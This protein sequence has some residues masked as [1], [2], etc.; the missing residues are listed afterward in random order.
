MKITPELIRY[1]QDNV[2]R[3]EDRLVAGERVGPFIVEPCEQFNP[4]LRSAPKVEDYVRPRIIFW[5]PIHQHPFFKGS[6]ACPHHD[7]GGEI[8]VLTPC[9][10]KDGKSERD[11]PRAIYCV[12][13]PLLLVSRVYRCIRGH[14]IAGHDPRLLERIPNGDVTFHL[15]HK[16]GISSQLC[17]LVFSLASS[18]QTFNEIEI[19]LAQRYLDSF[20]ERECRYARHIAS[21]L[22][23]NTVDKDS[24]APFPSFDIWGPTP[25]TDTI[26][27]CFLCVYKENRLFLGQH[28]SDTTA[29]SW[30]SADHTF[31]VAA[32]IGCY[33]PD[34]SWANQFDSL[35]IVLNEL[36]QVLTYKL[37]K[38]TAMNKVEDILK[39]LKCRLEQQGT[40]CHTI[41]V[42]NCCTVR[43]KFTEIFPD[44]LIKLDLFH[45]IQRVTSKVPKDRKHYLSPSFINDFRMIFRAD[46]DQGVTREMDT[47]DEG[48][49]MSNLEK[50]AE[51]WR[52]VCYDS[53]EPVLNGNICRELENLKIHIKKGCL[54]R[55][56]TGGGSARNENLHKNL[57]SVIAR[58]KLGCELAEALLATFFYVWNERRNTSGQMP[59]GCVKP[60]LS[61]R[62]ELE[63]HGF[64]PT[65]ERFGIIPSSV[66]PEEQHLPSSCSPEAML[67]IL[68]SIGCPAECEEH[69]TENLSECDLHSVLCQAVN[70]SVVYSHLKSLCNSPKLNPRLIHLMPCSLM[71]FSNGTYATNKVA[72]HSERLD[73]N[74]M[75]YQLKVNEELHFNCTADSMFLS[76]ISQLKEMSPSSQML[77][78]H[79]SN[80]G[81][82]LFVDDNLKNIQAL[83]TVVVDE[84]LS[85]AVHYKHAMLTAD[86]TYEEETNKF[87]KCGY[88]SSK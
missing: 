76:V 13:G 25:S 79:L 58:S 40:M 35:F 47:P 28:M 77:Q 53:G 75:G 36:G 71:L 46:G 48:T 3:Y 27:Q 21:F 51:R 29:A 32:N 54:S 7:H 65:T 52:H 38:G 44:A 41:F 50:F 82:S 72:E 60:I 39:N 84:L 6:F 9:K 20:S 2:Q 22:S 14:E 10:W 88:Y 67:G 42:D 43:G 34:G 80:L 1:V 15:G 18:G 86:L 37:T 81:L 19:F 5:D 62:A 87:K 66:D 49:L 8:S 24:L 64:V 31:K 73:K 70:A 16:L 12:N 26:L 4:D 57:R 30:I 78:E 11:L 45:A 63:H 33:L 69:I 17:S 74:L 55:I 85:N 59:A 68:H 56:P 61:Y 23:T 83:R